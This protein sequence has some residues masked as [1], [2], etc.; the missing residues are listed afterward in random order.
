[1]SV[2]SISPPK[3]M[4]TDLKLIQE[5]KKRSFDKEYKYI[6]MARHAK[7]VSEQ[8]LICLLTRK[9]YKLKFLDSRQENS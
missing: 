2:S 6:H 7:Y 4:I 8:V 9:F 3:T 1:M 5:A